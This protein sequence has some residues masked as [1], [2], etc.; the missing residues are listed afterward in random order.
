MGTQG[1]QRNQFAFVHIHRQRAL[2]RYV[3]CPLRAML[4]DCSNFTYQWYAGVRQVGSGV[5]DFL[6]AGTAAAGRFPLGGLTAVAG[7]ECAPAASC[8][9]GASG[10]A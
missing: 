4:V 7:G 3:E 2:C 5:Q 8:T 9:L 6:A 10:G 1:H